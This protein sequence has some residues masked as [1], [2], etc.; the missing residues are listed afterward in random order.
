MCP[1]IPPPMRCKYISILAILDKEMFTYYA[2]PRVGK[3][4][5]QSATVLIGSNLTLFLR[6]Q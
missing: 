3:G 1:D 4:K 5:Q 2:I 6:D